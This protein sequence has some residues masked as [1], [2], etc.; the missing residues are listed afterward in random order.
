MTRGTDTF[1]LRSFRQY[2]GSSQLLAIASNLISHAC[3]TSEL[4][5]ILV[6]SWP[7]SVVKQI[8]EAMIQ[9]FEGVGNHESRIPI[10]YCCSVPRRRF[11]SCWTKLAH[12]CGLAPRNSGHFVLFRGYST[13]HTNANIPPIQQQPS[14]PALWP[15]FTSVSSL[16][17]HT[18]LP[19]LEN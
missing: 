9:L 3:C 10:D 5:P 19:D 8:R 4:M 6:H 13:S 18:R 1:W 16:N 17:C 15:C 12:M 2:G 7:E 11:Y 14:I